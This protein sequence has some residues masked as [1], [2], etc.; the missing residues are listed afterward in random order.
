MGLEDQTKTAESPDLKDLFGMRQLAISKAF[1]LSVGRES[2]DDPAAVQQQLDELLAIRMQQRALLQS[3]IAKRAEF[4]M[5]AL[6][7]KS[8]SNEKQDIDD[9]LSTSMRSLIN[10]I[11]NTENTK[12]KSSLDGSE[13][14]DAEQKRLFFQEGAIFND[15]AKSSGIIR[16]LNDPE[17]IENVTR[18]CGHQLSQEQLS[19]GDSLD[20]LEEGY[21]ISPP[22]LSGG[23]KTFTVSGGKPSNAAPVLG[24][25]LTGA[26]ERGFR[27]DSFG[28]SSLEFSNAKIADL[29]AK[30]LGL[31][32]GKTGPALRRK[33][34]PPEGYLY[35]YS[36]WSKLEQSELAELSSEL[37]ELIFQAQNGDFVSDLLASSVLTE[38]GGALGDVFRKKCHFLT[39]CAPLSL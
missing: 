17:I 9:I 35:G 26:T 24:R 7:E 38:R 23:L 12:D 13:L 32:N 18:A 6:R 14:M 27:E 11:A 22:L 36:E 4:E 10:L 3:V 16:M 21:S 25:L 8:L 37:D 1:E 39:Y 30:P 2:Y 33:V 20:N 29:L 15:L 31:K 34:N 28:G 19:L 5:E